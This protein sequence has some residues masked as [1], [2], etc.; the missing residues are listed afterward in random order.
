M[1]SK[2]LYFEVSSIQTNR[3]SRKPPVIRFQF[4]VKY[5]KRVLTCPERSAGPP[6]R[7]KDTKM[8]SP[9]SPPTMLKPRPVPA[10][11]RGIY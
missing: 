6:A 9:S 11:V 7:M 8:P 3:A 10:T 5:N 1:L 4:K 2:V